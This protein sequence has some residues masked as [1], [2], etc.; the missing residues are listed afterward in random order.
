MLNDLRYAFR[1]LLK[2]PGFSSIAI[3][4]LALGIGAN[5]AIF[6]VVNAV[7]LRPLPFPHS[8]QLVRIFGTQPQLAK[9]P[10]SPA[11]FLDWQKQNQVFTAIAAYNGK[12][13]NILGSERPERLRGTAVS[14]E[15]F[16]VLQVQPHLGRAFTREEDQAGRG[17]VVVISDTLWE[18]RFG[19]DRNVI[20]QSVLLNDKNYTVIGVMP[21]GFAFPD[22]RTE[23]WAPLAFEAKE[24]VVRDTNYLAVIARLKPGI[25]F[26]QASAQM[27]AVAHQAGVQN[28]T[29]N[30]GVGVKLVTLNDQIVGD[31]RPVLLVLLGAVGFVL[32]IA[33][34]NVANLFL[35]RA[36][37]RQKEMA[38][39]SALGASRW[40]MV[41]LLL[42]E[43][44]LIAL[45]GGGFRIAARSLGN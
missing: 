25:S 4:T 42:M 17:E 24:A 26:E 39:R 21:R 5:A 18:R 36:A 14:A 38:I 13:F 6:S 8:E 3:L 20:G 45:V 16:A 23:L 1:M 37:T 44:V 10:S 7:L 11:N 32:L 9:A 34:A 19:G 27:T 41:R 2:S 29:T 22:I 12:G 31:I 33:C 40:R 15:I 30:T 28:P 35:A 43:S